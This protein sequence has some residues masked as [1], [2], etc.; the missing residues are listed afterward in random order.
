[1]NTIPRR[2]MLGLVAMSAALAG[3][4]PAMAK[5][6]DGDEYTRQPATIA[7]IGLGRGQAVSASVVWLPLR[8]RTET[9][10]SRDAELVISEL[11][12]K[13]LARKKVTLTPFTG[14]SLEWGLPRG[15]S[16]QSVFGYT[17]ADGPLEDIYSTL[18][19]FDVASG[20]TIHAMVDPTG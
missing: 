1:M 16:R 15:T 7:A 19:V 17:F 14:A 9:P 20:Q 18:E 10:P 4:R 8:G 6:G 3:A 11:N 13:E 12:G 2:S 5:T